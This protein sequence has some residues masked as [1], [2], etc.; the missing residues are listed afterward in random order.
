M[1]VQSP[2]NIS[3]GVGM[4]ATGVPV[5]FLFIYIRKPEPIKKMLSIGVGM[6]ATGVPVYFLFI[7]I[8]KPEP[9]K[10][11]LILFQKPLHHCRYWCG[12]DC[13]RRPCIFL[14]HLHQ[15][16]RANQENAKKYDSISSEDYDGGTTSEVIGALD[17]FMQKLMMVCKPEKPASL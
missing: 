17:G 14:V 8:R 16:T 4:I 1:E 5:Y 13:N 7:Y 6:I 2:M 11:M 3:I 15:E 9:I 10:K 12:D